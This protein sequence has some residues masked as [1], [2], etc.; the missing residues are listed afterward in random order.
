VDDPT[1]VIKECERWVELQ[2]FSK[3]RPRVAV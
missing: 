2:R 3:D 1:G